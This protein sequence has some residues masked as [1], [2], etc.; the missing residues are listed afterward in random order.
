MQNITYVTGNYGKYISVKEDGERLVAKYDEETITETIVNSLEFNNSIVTPLI[1]EESWYIGC[2]IS[3][4]DLEK[5]NKNIL[6]VKENIYL[7]GSKYIS[8]KEDGERLA[9]KYD[10]E[11]EIEVR[12]KI[13]D[14]VEKFTDA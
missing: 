2:D 8:I 6:K 7:I 9:T 1:G 4:E 11:F 13:L 3:D 14:E 12:K 10:E 5:I